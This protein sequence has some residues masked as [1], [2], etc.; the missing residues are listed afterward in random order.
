MPFGRRSRPW[1][2]EREGPIAARQRRRMGGIGPKVRTGPKGIV[3]PEETEY[4][5]GLSC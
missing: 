1:L 3:L 2:R 5:W 4:G